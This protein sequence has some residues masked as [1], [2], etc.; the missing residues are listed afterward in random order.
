MP[1]PQVAQVV[2]G[3]CIS[4][5]LLFG[6]LFLPRYE[7][8]PGWVGL[9]YATPFF[10]L[11]RALATNQFFCLGAGCPTIEVPVNGRLQVQGQFAYVQNYLGTS[12]TSRFQFGE[13]GWATL[14]VA[15]MC[16]IAVLSL[17]LIVHVRR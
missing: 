12:Y 2:G 17:G 4:I 10:H 5:I 16:A 13:L 6:G 8:P 11:L 3:L 15:V 7:M 9:Q 14:A 1:T